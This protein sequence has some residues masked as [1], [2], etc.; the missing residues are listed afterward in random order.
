MQPLNPNWKF[1][2]VFN[3]IVVAVA[4]M[5]NTNMV[6]CT[7]AQ[8]DAIRILFLIFHHNFFRWFWAVCKVADNRLLLK[9]LLLLSIMFCHSFF[10]VL[11]SLLSLSRQ[12][13]LSLLQALHYSFSILKRV[14]TFIYLLFYSIQNQCLVDLA[15]RRCYHGSPLPIHILLYIIFDHGVF[16]PWLLQSSMRSHSYL[17]AVSIFFF[18]CIF[19]YSFAI[20]SLFSPSENIAV[21][22][23]IIQFDTIRSV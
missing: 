14:W 13:W 18:V 4:M 8:I 15:L 21:A 22:L 12:H 9:K 11:F 7:I 5:T 10:V 2:A 19:F 1:G 20:L 16:I 17:S 3:F 23:L 6:W